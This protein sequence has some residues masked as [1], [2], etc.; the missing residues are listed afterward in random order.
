MPAVI[1]LAET[2]AEGF[3]I[4]I[5]DFYFIGHRISSW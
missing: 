4:F 2:F 1:I 3:Q 5:I